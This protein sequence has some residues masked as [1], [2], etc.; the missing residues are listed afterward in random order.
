MYCSFGLNVTILE[1]AVYVLFQ[2]LAS[3]STF[4]SMKEF[5]KSVEHVH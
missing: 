2:D 5:E 4:Y 1:C 3:S